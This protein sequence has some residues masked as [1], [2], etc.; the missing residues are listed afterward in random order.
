[1]KNKILSYLLG[2]LLAILLNFSYWYVQADCAQD[3]A[4]AGIEGKSACIQD[5]EA[6]GKIEEKATECPNWCCGIKLNTNFPI[7]WNCIWNRAEE[8]PTNAFP[9]MLSA[10]TKLAM[11]LILIMSFILIIYAGILWAADKPKEAK[12]WLKRVAITILILWFS[13]VILKLINPNFFS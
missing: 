1:M 8:N 2:W 12:W 11:S 7:I 3:C 10:L 5:C 13:W 6:K 9:Y 4:I